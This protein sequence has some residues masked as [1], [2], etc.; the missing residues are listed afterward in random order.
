V[1]GEQL[2]GFGH[3][4]YRDGDPRA[5]WLL[6]KLAALGSGAA[7]FALTVASQAGDM[8]GERPNLDFAL[9]ALARA[10]RLPA[11]AP[12][13]LF[14]VGRCAGWIGHALEQYAAGS[15]IRPRARYVGPA[16]AT[17]AP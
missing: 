1:R 11:G 10:I 2:P 9:A 17:I 6:E 7:D 12:L 13:A 5:A 14:A 15:L 16:P 3:P 4:L 8:T